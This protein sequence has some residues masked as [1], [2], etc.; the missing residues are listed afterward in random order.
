MKSLANSLSNTGVTHKISKKTNK[1]KPELMY[2]ILAF[3]SPILVIL[4]WYIAS[5]KQL[6][7]SQILVPPQTVWNTFI[8]LLHS[9]ELGMHLKD[10]LYRLVFGFSIAT[11][12][13]IF[14]G[15]LYATFTT[16][17]NYTYVLFNVLYQIPIFVL[18]PIFILIFG[19][20]EIFKI[21]LIIKACFF[22]IALATADA[23]KNIPKQY[24]EL[25]KIYKF[26][27]WSWLKFIIFPTTLPPVI[28]GLRIALG[29]AWLILVAVEL[30]A[31]GTGIGQMME[32]ARQ[33]LR[34]DIVMVGVFITG[35]IGFSL[36]KVLRLLEQRFSRYQPQISGEKN[37]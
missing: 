25:G 16:F 8:S 23:V 1:I 21:L 13:G 24:I 10:S 17:R 3:L 7:P 26:K 27:T 15:I 5:E 36:D 6:F 22:P 32:L 31:A 2:S 33:M 12:S 29:R 9:G 37:V 30:L 34:L 20:G 18:I 35:L 14:F 28:S 11:I 19:I 4:L